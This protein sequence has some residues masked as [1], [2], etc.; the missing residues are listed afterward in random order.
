MAIF[1]FDVDQGSAAWFKLRS[2]IPT[3]SN[4]D[5]IIT[6]AKM[7]MATARFKYACRLIAERLLNLQ[8]ESLDHVKH[9]EQGRRL[10]PFAVRQLEFT[11]ELETR[12]VGFV[13]TNDKRFGASPDRVAP[14]KVIEVKAPAIETH[15]NYL[16]FGQGTAYRCQVQGQ[17]WVADAEEAIFY[18]FIERGPPYL[19]RT[20]RD[21]AF[22]RS[23]RGALEQF[24]DELEAWTEKA[25]SLGVWQAFAEIVP[26]VEAENAANLRRD[27]LTTEQ[28]LAE[29]IEREVDPGYEHRAGA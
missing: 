24:S 22:I 16:L 5:D 21:E 26:P 7:Q 28:E 17:L 15:L 20:P 23:M 11:T 6:P 25:R 4:F 8:T 12:K 29:L 18:S 10:E 1:H 9:I 14:A 27:P 2:G 13:T 19:V 3:A